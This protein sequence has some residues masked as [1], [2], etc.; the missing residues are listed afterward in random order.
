MKPGSLANARASDWL[1]ATACLLM[2]LGAELV[3]VQPLK[4]P[5]HRALPTVLALLV[6]GRL[7]PA[8]VALGY[9]L[10]T[11]AIVAFATPARANAAVG[12]LWLVAAAVAIAIGRKWR[13]SLIPF[14]SFGAVF[15][16]L[17][18]ATATG[19]HVGALTQIWGNA[20]FA[21]LG[22]S[23]AYVVLRSLEK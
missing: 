4:L 8:P 18:A 15:G 2:S 1:L 11:P 7:L 16:V 22:A 23:S 14:V 6:F 21:M 10:L 20:L 13:T 3:S 5:G 12:L 17:R 19:A 9:A